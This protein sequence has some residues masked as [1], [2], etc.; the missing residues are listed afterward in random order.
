MPSIGIDFD[1]TLAL[2]GE[3]FGR[4]AVERGLLSVRANGAKREIRN[5]IRVLPDGEQRW[6]ELQALAYGPRIG[7]AAPA[8][9]AREFLAAARRGGAGLAVVSHKTRSAVADQGG[10]DLREA[11]LGWLDVHGFFAEP[12]SLRR[13]DV[14]FEPTRSAKLERIETLGCTHFVDDLEETFAEAAFPAGVVRILYRPGR[15]DTAP[16]GVHVARSWSEIGELVLG[17]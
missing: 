6:R 5:A 15:A 11:A 16:A 2:Y 17:G 7:E 8:E 10:P 14:H 12:V 1:N 9:G 4:L 13:E 3:L